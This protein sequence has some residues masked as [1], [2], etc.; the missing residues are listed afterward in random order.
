[1]RSARWNAR[2]PPTGVE[3]V[4]ACGD[5]EGLRVRS[6]DGYRIALGTLVPKRRGTRP[7]QAACSRPS[8]EIW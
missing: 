4:F 6:E 1:V 8:D 2:E 3:P 5:P 7:S